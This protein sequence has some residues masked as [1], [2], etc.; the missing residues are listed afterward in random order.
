M[1]YRLIKVEWRDACTALSVVGAVL[2]FSSGVGAK[3]H[4]LPANGK[5]G[6]IPEEIYQTLLNNK[7]K[8]NLVKYT[9]LT[10]LSQH[11]LPLTAR[12]TLFALK[13]H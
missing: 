11:K 1:A 9:P 3:F 8:G 4:K 7:K 5:Q 13:N 10:L 12:N 2:V 6:P